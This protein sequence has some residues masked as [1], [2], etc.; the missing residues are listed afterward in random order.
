MPHVYILR[1][2]IRGSLYVGST[3]DLCQRL[4]H[5]KNGGTPTTKRFGEIELVFSQ[6]YEDIK[7]ARSIERK[8][9]KL[10]RREEITLK[11]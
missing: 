10:K 3:T 5:H 11:E 4:K 6:Y 8:L 1:S 9:K 2:K 7:N